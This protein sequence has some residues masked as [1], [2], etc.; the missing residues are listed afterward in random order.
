M[1]LEIASAAN[2]LV[3]LLRLSSV[4][5]CE[6]ILQNFCN[7][8]IDV[9]Q[10]KYKNRWFPSKPIKGVKYRCILINNKLDT[11]ICEAGN[12]CGLSEQ[13]LNTAFPRNLT[14]WINPYEVSY[15]I[16]QHGII[17]VLYKYSDLKPWKPSLN[18]KNNCEIDLFNI[19]RQNKTSELKF[20][21]VCNNLCST[22]FLLEP[23]KMSIDIEKLSLYV[24]K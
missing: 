19:I 1:W 8:L 5:K 7:C 11:I 6:Y 4:I 3:H 10:Q 21:D 13:L 2:F 12:N 17:C 20:P 23:N 15:Q 16:G 9:F 24:S 22:N 18:K 14:I